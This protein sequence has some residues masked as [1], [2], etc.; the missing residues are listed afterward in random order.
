ME[1]IVMVLI[2]TIASCFL[3]EI[4]W[5]KP[6]WGPMAAGLVPRISRKTLFL[7]VGIVGATVMPH[8]LFLHS[9]LVQ[10]RRI[11]KSFRE[12]RDAC[13]FNLID[14]AVALNGAMLVNAAILV[15]S[16]AVFFRAG[17]QVT[18]IGQAY[19][20]LTPLLGASFAS[21]LFGV[22]L[23]CS[24]QSS[25]ITGTLAGQ[26]VM[27]G[28]LDIRVRPWLRRLLTRALAVIPAALVVWY[29]GAEG[30]YS[31]IL[32]SQ[33]ILSAQ[34]PFAII[35]LI[36]FTNDPKRMGAFASAPWLRVLS[37]LSAILIVALNVWLVADQLN[38]FSSQAGRWAILLSDRFRRGVRW[39]GWSAWVAHLCTRRGKMAFAESSGDADGGRRSSS[40]AGVQPDFGHAGP[41]PAG[42]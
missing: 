30:T 14:S 24:G 21:I 34:L 33:V 29:H 12:M 31:L 4:F 27:E 9:A 42:P 7:V 26:I 5:A 37:W 40:A 2:V 3:V 8:N 36:H 13:R 38:D 22:A 39:I 28:F 1:M 20:L 11:G 41:L 15:L 16:A 25:T 10:T 19:Q 6:D 35:P 17:K 23:L 32:L 18:E